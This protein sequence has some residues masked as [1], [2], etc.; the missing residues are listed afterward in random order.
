MANYQS[1]ST[2]FQI[3]PA[4]APDAQI[5]VIQSHIP[6]MD[7]GFNMPVLLTEIAPKDTKIA[8]KAILVMGHFDT[9]AS[10]TSIDF[11]ISEK[12]G[13][14]PIGS[15]L[16]STANG[17]A[18]TPNYILNLFFPDTQLKSFAKIQVGSCDLGFNPERE[19]NPKNMGLLIGRDIMSQWN[20]V[21][22][23]PTSSVFVSD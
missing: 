1:F 11:K 2:T 9:G 19:L 4:L 6:L 10:K 7:M 3:T 16:I 17:T 22:N 23:G 12:L 15:S 14:V 18:E 13:L 20:I 21:W 8:P 5:S